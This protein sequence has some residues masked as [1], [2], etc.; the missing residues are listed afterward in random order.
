MWSIKAC[1]GSND[2]ENTTCSVE[3]G[4]VPPWIFWILSSFIYAWMHGPNVSEMAFSQSHHCTVKRERSLCLTPPPCLCA[5]SP[6]LSTHDLPVF[7]PG[8]FRYSVFSLRCVLLPIKGNV[9]G[10]GWIYTK[11]QGAVSQGSL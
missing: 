7:F 10:C 3:E 8:L 11:N 5:A 9:V 4:F 6:A 1:S 2:K